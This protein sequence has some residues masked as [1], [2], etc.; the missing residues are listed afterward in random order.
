MMV[1]ASIV[2]A[3]IWS[4][5][6]LLTRHALKQELHTANADLASVERENQ[7]LLRELKLMEQDPIVLER[8]VAEEL[9]WG[10]EG[11]VIYRFS[12]Q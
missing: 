12:D 9:A 7:R 11:A 1:F 6:G 4:H 10:R 8:M 5:N 3:A 2:A